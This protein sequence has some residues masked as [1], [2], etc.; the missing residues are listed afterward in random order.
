MIS[1]E[2]EAKQF[3]SLALTL[4]GLLL[5]IWKCSTLIFI[6]FYVRKTFLLNLFLGKENRRKWKDQVRWHFSCYGKTLIAEFDI[7]GWKYVH[8]LYQHRIIVRTNHI[9]LVS[10]QMIIYNG[11]NETQYIMIN[12]FFSQSRKNNKPKNRNKFQ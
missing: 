10:E 4:F 7:G 3:N 11:N 9:G 12:I 1:W 6:S 5:Q 2:L 8:W